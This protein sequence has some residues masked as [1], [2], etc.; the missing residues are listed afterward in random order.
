MR[1]QAEC[2]ALLEALTTD[3]S[4][5]LAAAAI[6]P[7]SPLHLAYV[8]MGIGSSSG[9]SASAEDIGDAVNRPKGVFTGTVTTNTTGTNF[10]QLPSTP[11]SLIVLYNRSGV[12]ISWRYGASGQELRIANGIGESIPVVANAD[13]I[14][15]RRT[16]QSNTSVTINFRGVLQ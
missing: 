13:E 11:A 5:F 16:D 2:L 10:I 15:L 14:R 7:G 8:L 12:E 6:P 1:N 9:S 3:Y 4:N